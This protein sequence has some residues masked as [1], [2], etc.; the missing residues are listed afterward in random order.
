MNLSLDNTF[1][2]IH[3][4]RKKCMY[5]RTFYVGTHVLGK[6]TFFVSYIK[7]TNFDAQYDYLWEFFLS[8]LLRPHK[9]FFVNLCAN[10]KYL[11][12]HTKFIF[13]F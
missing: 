13:T 7:K 11:N 5:I 10:I 6:I 2:N 4:N 12:L 1:K 9:M 8:F 3:K